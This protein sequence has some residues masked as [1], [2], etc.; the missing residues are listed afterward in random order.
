VGIEC[1]SCR[2][3]ADGLVSVR[4]KVWTT[5]GWR[6]AHAFNSSLAGWLVVL[7]IRHVES[8]DEL[9][10]A[11][12]EALGK[13]LRESSRASKTVTGCQKT[14]V[15]MF[16]EA[17]GFSHL[18]FHVVP[19][20]SDFAEDRLGPK[21][22]AYLKEEPLSDLRRDQISLQVRNAFEVQESASMNSRP[23]SDH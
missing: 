10:V 17:E 4:E 13:L 8:V 11:E 20:M 5:P 16:A 12:S 7:P 19:R 15:M 23:A 3:E 14:Y 9:T 1:Y 22:F 6:V 21:V 2:Q 18:H